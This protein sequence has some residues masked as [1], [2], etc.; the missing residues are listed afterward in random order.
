MHEF[1]VVSQVISEARKHG[2]PVEIEIEVGDIAG[3]TS[4]DLSRHMKAFVSWKIKIKKMPG[5]IECKKCGHRAM[6][7]VISRAH[8]CVYLKCRACGSRDYDIVSGDKII[9]KSVRVK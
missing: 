7:A 1:S 4:S 5:A 3:M 8:D 2:E 6:P 9:L